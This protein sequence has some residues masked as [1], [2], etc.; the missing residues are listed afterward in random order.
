MHQNAIDLGSK[1]LDRAR[2]RRRAPCAQDAQI[3]QRAI[4]S[5]QLAEGMSAFL[6]KRAPH[7]PRT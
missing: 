4:Q 5:S 2:P 1:Y 3:F 6:E 7:W